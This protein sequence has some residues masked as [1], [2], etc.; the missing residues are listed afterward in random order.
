MQS[1]E[2]IRAL[3]AAGFKPKRTIRAVMFMDEENGGTGADK[4]LDE[5][6]SKKEKHVF[7]LESDAGGFTPRGF[8]LDM[9]DAQRSRVLQWK[10]LFLPYGV[11]EI[12]PGG[13]GADIS[14]LKVLGTA[15]AGF[16]PD[17]QRY[18]DLHHA[19][20]DTFEAVNKRE[21]DLGA[22]NMAAFIWLVSE[23][24]L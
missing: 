14:G 17:S 12:V 24:G 11:Y 18:F 10:G 1:I 21:L 16:S 2:V 20:T 5:A 3:N 13:S 4:Y 15:L 9:N 7:A 22:V 8:N 6:K 23:Y 19:A